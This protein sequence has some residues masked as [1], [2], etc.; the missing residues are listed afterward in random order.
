MDKIIATAL[1]IIAAV[2]GVGLVVNATLPAIGRSSGAMISGA[3]KVNDRIKTQ[4]SIV[5]FAPELDQGGDWK[6]TYGNADGN[7]D[8]FFWVKNVGAANISAIETSD[9]YF[10]AEGSVARINYGG[11][12]LPRWSYSIEGGGAAWGPTTTV[13]FTIIYSTP[14]ASPASPLAAGNYYLK[15]TTPNG[16][17]DEY[18]YIVS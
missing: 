2:V 9:V 16:I 12:G 8:V 13:K 5:H 14:G 4:I 3:D 11:A 7:F 10:G 1:L 6:N 18:N 17:P 15:I